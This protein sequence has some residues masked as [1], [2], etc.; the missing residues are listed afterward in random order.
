MSSIKYPA[1]IILFGEHTVLQGGRALAVPYPKFGVK[2]QQRPS[3]DGR[4]L[5]VLA[6]LRD[7]FAE[8]DFNFPQL[9]RDLEAGW[10]LVGNVPN[11]YGLG[12]S[13]T[14]CA[15]IYDRF[16]NGQRDVHETQAFLAQMEG[17]YHGQ[18]S[19]TDPLIS[20]LQQPLLLGAGRVVTTSLRASWHQ[21][22]FLLDSVQERIA[23][24]LVDRF[25][26][27]FRSDSDWRERVQNQWMPSSDACLNYLCGNDTAAFP[28]HFSRLSQLQA[29]LSPWLIPEKIKTIWR[30]DSYQLKLCGAGGGGF[31]LGYSTDWAATKQELVNYT[32]YKV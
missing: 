10:Q 1:K 17:F 3:P 18:S 5:A 24:P 25:I 7:H 28:T 21:G 15:A 2:W 4:L 23:G 13:G 11:G 32:I 31:M 29:E 30:G 8:T 19:G 20:L 22:L 9:K 6:Y 16:A 12:S 27:Q 14:V 26:H